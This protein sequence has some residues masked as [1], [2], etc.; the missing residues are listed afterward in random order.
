MSRS[1]NWF[2]D[3]A[4]KSNFDVRVFNSDYLKCICLLVGTTNKVG[5]VRV[6]NSQI[7]LE[8]IVQH[9]FVGR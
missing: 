5:L 2:S 8:I 6:R 4:S 1:I 9:C 7:R 3:S